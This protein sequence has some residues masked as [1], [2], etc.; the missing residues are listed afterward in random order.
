MNQKM[1]EITTNTYSKN[2]RSRKTTYD[3][4][5]TFLNQR[6]FNLKQHPCTHPF[7]IDNCPNK[8]SGQ[9]SSTSF[10]TIYK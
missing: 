7:T 6:I 2:Y 4:K 5:R 1:L 9:Y 8:V 10:A 3:R